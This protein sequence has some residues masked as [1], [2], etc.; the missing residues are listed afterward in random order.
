MALSDLLTSTQPKAIW[1]KRLLLV[2]MMLLTASTS[3]AMFRYLTPPLLYQKDF[4]QEYLFARAV[5]SH[6][7]PYQMISELAA[8]FLSQRDMPFFPH[9][10]PHP[11]AVIFIALPFGLLP[12]EQAQ[13][14][15]FI[16]EAFCLAVVLRLLMQSLFPGLRIAQVALIYLM[17]IP[18]LHVWEELGLGQLMMLQLLLLTA[19]WRAFRADHERTGAVCL[20]LTL[21]FKLIAW[22][23]IFLLITKRRWRAAIMTLGT[24]AGINLAAA[25]IIGP[26]E[27]VYYYSVVSRWVWS[28]YRGEWGNFSWMSIGWR[29]FEGTGSSHLT[30]IH[31]PPLIAAPNLIYPT[32]LLAVAIWLAVGLAWAARAPSFDCAFGLALCTSIL[33]SPLTWCHYLVLLAIPLSLMVHR[34]INSGFPAR[35]VSLLLLLIVLLSIPASLLHDVML[36]LARVSRP[37]AGGAVMPFAVSLID[38]LPT[39]ALTT[40]L[41][42]M[43][44]CD[45]MESHKSA[46]AAL[47]NHPAGGRA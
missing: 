2:A 9:P 30:P 27:A 12:Y 28:I 39:A 45:R 3:I 17:V 33:A 40:L 38:L 14:A 34:I 42:F 43:R 5:L 41:V 20:G 26:Y 18:L 23:L 24:F 15:W 47:I 32:S 44:Q 25:A 37:P 10:T 22:P 46:N 13:A 6:I 8:L 31:A 4:L 35:T 11:P 36:L 16:L 21:A 29:L 19:A 7:T 1:L